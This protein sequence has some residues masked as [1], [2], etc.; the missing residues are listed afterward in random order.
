MSK[1]N[2]SFRMIKVFGKREMELAAIKILDNYWSKPYTPID[3][4]IFSSEYEK[5]GFY[6]LRQNGWMDGTSMSESF[7]KRVHGR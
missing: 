3:P 2:D 5:A 6:F 7:W 1:K 4:N